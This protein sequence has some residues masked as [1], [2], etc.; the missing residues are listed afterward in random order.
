ML[1]VSVVVNVLRYCGALFLRCR[2]STLLLFRPG[3]RTSVIL[4][5]LIVLSV[6]GVC[7]KS[8]QY[9]SYRHLRNR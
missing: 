2:L 5:C 1:I 9:I 8:Q 3:D 6:H 7:P 4:I